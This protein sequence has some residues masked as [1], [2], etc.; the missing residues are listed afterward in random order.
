M[1]ASQP[2]RDGIMGSGRVGVA[3]AVVAALLLC[4]TGIRAMANDDRCPVIGST[5]RPNPED[6]DKHFFYRLRIDS[7]PPAYDGTQ[8]E[9]IMRFRMFDRHTKKLLSELRLTEGCPTGIGLCRIANPVRQSMD[10][11]SDVIGLEKSFRQPVGYTAPYAIVLPG[12]AVQNWIY[13]ENDV[14][15]GYLSY[16][17]TPIFPN[18]RSDIIWVRGSCGHKQEDRFWMM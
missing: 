16:T 7:F 18:L 6:W 15:L 1:T 5:Y 14:K 8:F 4:G 9:E 17:G 12:F 10:I 2:M 13:T 3:G 11:Y